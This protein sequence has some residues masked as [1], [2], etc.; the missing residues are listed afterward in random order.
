MSTDSC[1]SLCVRASPYYY[2]LITVSYEGTKIY[3]M[4]HMI[5]F[6]ANIFRG[7]VLDQ[8]EQI[9]HCFILPPLCLPKSRSFP[10]FRPV[11]ATPQMFAPR[12]AHS[13]SANIRNDVFLGRRRALQGR[14]L[15][16]VSNV[17]KSKRPS[18]RNPRR[19]CT[20]R[21]DAASEL[22]DGQIEGVCHV[23]D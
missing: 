6:R 11:S 13:L 16:K 7:F 17:W 22:E 14:A 19:C 21:A 8:T 5:A 23:P 3:N 2:L 10:R 1:I 9:N 20:V 12:A 18:L 4:F 15:L